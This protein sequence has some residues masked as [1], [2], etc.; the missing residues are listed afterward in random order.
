[1]DGLGPVEIDH[2]A[3]EVGAVLVKQLVGAAVL[4]GIQLANERVVLL[5]R[6]VNLKSVECA[7]VGGTR[8]L[9][10]GAFGVLTASPSGRLPSRGKVLAAQESDEFRVRK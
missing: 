10:Q 5:L 2:L 8:R 3:N 6:G 1:M 4:R 9:Y 7:V